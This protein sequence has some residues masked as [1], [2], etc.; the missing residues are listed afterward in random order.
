MIRASLASKLG[1]SIFSQAKSAEVPY[2]EVK[3]KADRLWFLWV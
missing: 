2:S 3:R 1:V